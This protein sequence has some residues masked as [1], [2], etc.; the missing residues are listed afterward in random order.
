MFINYVTYLSTKKKMER[1]GSY[2]Y[3]NQKY[4]QL[5]IEKKIFQLFHFKNS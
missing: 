1:Q 2:L 5:E 3:K 4:R